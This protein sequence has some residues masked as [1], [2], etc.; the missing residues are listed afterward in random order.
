MGVLE[1]GYL[2]PRLLEGAEPWVLL[3]M[4]S[5]L[6]SVPSRGC[7]R[8]GGLGGRCGSTQ[9][10]PVLLC[11]QV[12]GDTTQVGDR[13]GPAQVWLRVLQVPGSTWQSRSLPQ[14]V[15]SLGICVSPD[16]S[17]CG[18]EDVPAD[19]GR[20]GGGSA[21]PGWDLPTGTE[22]SP[23][24]TQG[25]RVPTWVLV[26]SFVV[27]APA[28]PKGWLK[29]SSWE[30]LLA[31]GPGALPSPRRVFPLAWGAPVPQ[32]QPLEPA[33][34]SL[35]RRGHVLPSCPLTLVGLSACERHGTPATA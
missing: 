27:L 12:V 3:P 29:C 28:D 2:Y 9:E 11:L 24:E 33:T 22:S 34:L 6:F 15:C 25:S 13:A 17:H 18:C 14:Q 10:T 5:T 30:T 1:R 19:T 31:W 35:L 16:P 23:R 32:T 21:S 7:A 8:G 26:G 4:P 20:R